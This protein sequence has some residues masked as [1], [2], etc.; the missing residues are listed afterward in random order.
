MIPIFVSSLACLDGI[1]NR[2]V[3]LTPDLWLEVEINQLCPQLACRSPPISS[4]HLPLSSQKSS[5]RLYP[6]SRRSRQTLHPSPRLSCATARLRCSIRS[7]SRYPLKPRRVC[8]SVGFLHYQCTSVRHSPES[9]PLRPC[10]LKISHVSRVSDWNG[11]MQ[12][13]ER[14]VMIPL[15]ARPAVMIDWAFGIYMMILESY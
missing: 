8:C 11:H 14:S 12:V 13:D 9:C 5:L 2:V 3:S 1:F 15:S 4:S 10:P 7:C 6:D